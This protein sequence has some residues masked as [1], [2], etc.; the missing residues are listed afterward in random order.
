[1]YYTGRNSIVNKKIKIFLDSIQKNLAWK[2]LTVTEK[3]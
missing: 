2:F 3:S 1:M